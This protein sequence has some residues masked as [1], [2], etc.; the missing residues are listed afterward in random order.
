MTEE[1]RSSTTELKFLYDMESNEELEM[2]ITLNPEQARFV[3][4]KLESGKYQTVDEVILEALH[5]LEEHE[6]TYE[7]WVIETRKKVE[8]GLA[9]LERGEGIPLEEVMAV[10]QEKVR[11][12]REVKR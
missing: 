11:K 2:N 1:Q 12:A 8:V 7:E 10:F 6:K 5:L 9:E 4:Q 3:Q